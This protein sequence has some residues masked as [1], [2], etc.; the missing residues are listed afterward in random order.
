MGNYYRGNPA[1]AEGQEGIRDRETGIQTT[2]PDSR[3]FIDFDDGEAG[4]AG[5]TVHAGAVTARR[6][7]R[8]DRG[9]TRRWVTSSTAFRAGLRAK[10]G[11]R[12]AAASRFELRG[13]EREEILQARAEGREEQLRRLAVEQRINLHTKRGQP[14]DCWLAQLDRRP[15]RER[16]SNQRA[17]SH[18]ANALPSRPFRPGWG[19]RRALLHRFPNLLKHGPDDGGEAKVGDGAVVQLVLAI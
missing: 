9:I 2:S 10:M 1:G 15:A 5:D 8:Q 17:P 11:E 18:Q 7:H 13:A 16:C 6:Q 14:A 12:D 3:H 4:C 19:G